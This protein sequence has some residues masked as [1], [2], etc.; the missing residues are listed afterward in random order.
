MINLNGNNWTLQQVGKD[1]Q[2]NAVVPGC[3]HMDLEKAG[4]I[5]PMNWRDNESKTTWIAEE[6]WS[7]SRTFQVSAEDMSAD[8]LMVVCEGLD[9]LATVLINGAEILNAD[10]MFRIWSCDIKT[11]LIVG[12]NNITINFDSPLPYIAERQENKF[13]HAWNIFR[14]EYLGRGHIRKMACSFGWDWGPIAPTAGIWKDIYIKPVFKTELKDVRIVQDHLNDGSVD[15]KVDWSV[16]A[17]VDAEITLSFKDEVVVSKNSVAGDNSVLLHVENPNLWWPAGLGEQ[18]LYDISIKITDEDKVLDECSKKIGLR[19]LELKRERDEAGESF[20]FAVNGKPF[21]A[22]GANWIPIKIYLPSITKEDY[23]KNLRDAVDANMNMIRVWGGG[24]FENEDFYDICDEKG[25]LV[26]Q[27]CMFACGSYPSEDE[28]CNS[29]RLETED[30]LKRLRHRAS[31]ALICGNNELEGA[32]MSPDPGKGIMTMEEYEKVFDKEL[33]NVV[34]ELCP[35]IPYIPGSPYTPV[36]DRMNASDQGSGDAHLWD[37][38]FGAKPFEVQ[39]TWHCRFMSEYG[40]QSFPELKTIESFTEPEDRNWTSYIM[41]YHQRSPPGNKTIY[42]YMLDWFKMPKDFSS[43]ITLSQI[44]QGMCLQ[45]AVEHLRRI[46]PHNSGVLYWQI[47]DM[48]PCASWST[49]DCLGNWKASHYIAKRFFEPELISI[50][51]IK[52]EDSLSDKIISKTIAME[53]HVSNQTFEEQDYTIDWKLVTTDGSVVKTDSEQLKV[54]PQSNRLVSSMNFQKETKEY[55]ERN[56]LFFAYL[57]KDDVIVSSNVNFF[58]KP[59]HIELKSAK[60]S[61]KVLEQVGNEYTISISSDVPTLWTQ[62]ELENAKM[63]DNFFNLD[64]EQSNV[65]K[66]KTSVKTDDIKAKIKIKS[67]LDL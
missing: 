2:W 39:R 13:L 49:V 58:V 52:D 19:T 56:L 60:Y 14:E 10:N 65:I 44:S 37:V 3:V 11:N 40:F 6:N 45:F 42:S 15:I 46:Q 33:Y 22:K 25:I 48:W 43:G 24:I 16:D 26:W 47:N 17:P 54:M 28:F 1:Q 50:L 64:G 67:L 21:F 38:W 41:D 36:G 31:L 9:T 32:F 35:E 53:I 34:Q 5:P 23:E 59:K 57:K 4:V 55:G 51:D 18:P 8:K 27:D 20:C 61:C 66:V 12:D 62:I 30:N 7:Y 63:S 29:I